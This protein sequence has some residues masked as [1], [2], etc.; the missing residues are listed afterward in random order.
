[1]D[2]GE[3]AELLA[4]LDGFEALIQCERL[5]AGASRQT[6]RLSVRVHGRVTPLIFRRQTPPSVSQAQGVDLFDEARLLEAASRVGVPAPQQVL[7]AP[8]GPEGGGGVFSEWLEGETLGARIARSPAFKKARTGL[9]RRCGEILARIHAMEPQ[10]IGLSR[11]LVRLSPE[12]AVRA[13]WSAYQ[14]LG[15]DYPVID[16]TA[17]WLL[18]HLPAERPHALVHGDFRNGNL[19]VRESGEVAAVLDWELCHIGDP[20]RDLG[21]LCTRS[22]R[23]GAAERP[24]GGFG[25]YEE[26]FEG[27]ESVAGAPVDRTSVRWWEVFGS[28][29]WAC[30]SLSMAQDYRTGADTAPEKPVIGRRS[31]EC[32]IDCVNMILP[33]RFERLPDPAAERSRLPAADELLSSVALF[34][35][36]AVAP[37]HSGRTGFHA[38]VAANSLEI[39]GRELLMRPGAEAEEARRLSALLGRDGAAGDL[40]AELCRRIREDVIDS[41]DEGLAAYLRF[42]ALADIL[43]DQPGYPGALAALSEA[44]TIDVTR[45]GPRRSGP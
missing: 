12:E 14:A 5:S 4:K 44:R 18:A 30:A 10:D 33:G 35:R 38:R 25:D 45:D 22:W 2:A 17:R 19:M 31:S 9:A 39:V 21:W 29:W 13:S 34:L 8:G 27:Y 42:V 36:Q 26:L 1:M 15:A 28:F 6:F 37:A 20:M 7:L 16:H 3:I 41:S 43:I 40:R 11:P 32:R 23:F 24:V